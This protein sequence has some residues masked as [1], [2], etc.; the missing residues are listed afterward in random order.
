MCDYIKIML[1]GINVYV[2]NL[3][4]DDVFVYF[5]LILNVFY[6]SFCRYISFCSELFK[7]VAVHLCDGFESSV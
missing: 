1:M 6:I 4:T 7:Y 3:V 2:P 5:G